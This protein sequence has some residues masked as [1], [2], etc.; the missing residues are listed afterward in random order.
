MNFRIVCAAAAVA[1]SFASEAA[2]ADDAPASDITITGSAAIV[3]QYRFRG[4]AQS[5]NKPVVQGAIT[6]AHKSGFYISTWGSSASAGASPINIGGTEI[7]VYGGY[8]H[9]FS[10]SGVTIDGGG[11]GYIY[12]GAPNGNYYELYGSLAKAFGP[13]TA[14]VGVYYAPSQRVF[15]F[16]FTSPTHHNA[17]VYGE[18]GGSIPNTPISIHTHLG[19]TGGGFDWGKPYL[20]YSA[21]VSYKYK[22]LTFDMSIVGT[23]VSKTDINNGFGCGGSAVCIDSFHRMSKTVGVGSV[24]ASF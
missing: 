1:L 5:D 2:L 20:D 10:G 22:A 7:D 18:L 23:N 9:T 19:H 17:Y 12:P 15:N 3:S 11:Y 8:T 24:T 6:V 13:A 21:G 14:K 4:L 16:N